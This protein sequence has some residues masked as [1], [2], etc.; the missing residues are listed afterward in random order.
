M[1]RG[2]LNISWAQLGAELAN[3]NDDDQ[4]EFFKGFV[5]ECMSWETRHQAEMQM[6]SI[7][8]R[9]SD[10]EKE[11]LSSISYRGK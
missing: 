7:A 8:S 1:R 10:D 6:C 4:S 5:K 11:F 3:S 2:L 9:L